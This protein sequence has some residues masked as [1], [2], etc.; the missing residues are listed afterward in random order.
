[1]GTKIFNPF[2]IKLLTT[3]LMGIYFFF[4]ELQ[5]DLEA[6]DW[7]GF[8]MDHMAAVLSLPLAPYSF[9]AA[10]ADEAEPCPVCVV[11]AAVR[12]ALACWK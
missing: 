9:M 12:S 7:F 1:M 2:Y 11:L 5:A 8:R 6:K 10:I 4:S 3:T